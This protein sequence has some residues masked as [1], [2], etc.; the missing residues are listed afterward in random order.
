MTI[1]LPFLVVEKRTRRSVVV[2]VPLPMSTTTRQMKTRIQR[3][4]RRKRKRKM[5]TAAL[6][7]G[8]RLR[9]SEISKPR[10]RSSRHIRERQMMN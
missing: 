9:G 10:S 5:M 8:L 4:E 6:K 3:R 7:M 1:V 2:T